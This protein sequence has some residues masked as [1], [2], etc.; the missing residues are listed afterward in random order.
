MLKYAIIHCTATPA[1]RWVTSADIRN[2]HTSPKP[3][4]RGWKQVGYADMIHL[5]GVIE[6]LVAYNEDSKVDPWEITNGVAGINSQSRHVV[7][8]GGTFN[9]KPHD[10]RT[11]AQKQSLAAWVQMT[12]SF[13][14][15]ILFAGHYQFDSGKACPSFDVPKWLKEIGIPEQNIYEV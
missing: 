9:G 3:Q 5:D 12:L 13:N 6:N 2:W 1:G 7:Y 8:V 4:G 14:T 11:D 15:N 10:T